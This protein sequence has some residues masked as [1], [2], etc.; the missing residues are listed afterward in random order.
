MLQALICWSIKRPSFLYQRNVFHLLVMHI[1]VPGLP[2][3]TLGLKFLSVGCSFIVHI[4]D[5][6]L[7]MDGGG[8]DRIALSTSLSS[9]EDCIL[10]LSKYREINSGYI[11]SIW[12]FG[13]IGTLSDILWQRAMILSSWIQ[14]H[15]SYLRLQSSPASDQI[16]VWHTTPQLYS[17]HVYAILAYLSQ[18]NVTGNCVKQVLRDG[19]AYLSWMFPSILATL[20]S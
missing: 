19:A 14:W 20:H 12:L 3:K 5:T 4:S 1:P 13:L 8:V 6:V 18:V 9:S 7:W 15:A 17:K 11:I 2:Q 16:F 10:C